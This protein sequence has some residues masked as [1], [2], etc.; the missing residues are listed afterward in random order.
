[1]KDFSDKEIINGIKNNDSKILN[2]VYK[3]ML[4]MVKRMVENHHGNESRADDVFQDTMITICRKIRHD[5]VH[6]SSKFSTYLY[7][8]SK[9]IWL[10]E[11][12]SSRNKYIKLGD[13]PDMVHEP[14]EED[15]NFDMK[16]HTIIERHIKNLSKDCQKILRLH[17]NNATI[18]EIQ[19]IMNYNSPHHTMDRKYRCKKRLISQIQNDP[20]F[21][22]LSDEYSGKNRTIY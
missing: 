10:R 19:E 21:K 22:K 16:Y 20:E 12:F 13:L 4:P 3:S 17:I 2:Y 5:N 11:L 18:T 15:S 9:K 14:E 1:V 8:I 7:S 6:I